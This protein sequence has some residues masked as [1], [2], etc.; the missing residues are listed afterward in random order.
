MKRLAT[1]LLISLA[2]LVGALGLVELGLRLSGY[3]PFGRMFASLRQDTSELL[4]LG[5][6]RESDDEILVYELVPGARAHA[7]GADVEVN[8]LGFR[9]HPPRDP[10]APR[11]IVA[12]G[13]SATFG[14]KLPAEVLWPTRLEAALGPD[15]EVL[16]LGVVGYDVLEEVRF[17]ERVGLALAPDLVVV[18]YHVND[19]GFASPS[20]EYVRRLR[21]YGAPLYRL[22][23]AQWLRSWADRRA[24]T[25]QHRETD[26]E[27]YFVAENRQHI[28]DLAGDTEQLARIEALARAVE[29]EPELQ[30]GAHRYLRWYRSPSRIGKLR[31]ALERLAGHARRDGFEVLVFPVPW[32]ADGGLEP[33]YDLAFDVVRAEVERAGL[34]WLDTLPATRAAGHAGLRIEPGDHGHPDAQGHRLLAETL[35]RRLAARAL[36]AA[37]E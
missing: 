6:L 21:S 31:T 5:F 13:D 33:A 2:A 36:P 3:D 30:G 18:G 34:E 8:A 7:F 25:R 14:V 24:L 23:L 22:R 26:G 19:V 16:N 12:L 32:L 1:K 29:A 37:D 35:A 4:G 10:P 17:L 15:T 9:D 20:R 27:D 11:R 28:A